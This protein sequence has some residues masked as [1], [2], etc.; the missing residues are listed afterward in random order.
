MRTTSNTY[1]FNFEDCP[2][3]TEGEPCEGDTCDHCDNQLKNFNVEF[4]GVTNVPGCE[5]DN[6]VA[7]FWNSTSFLIT[8]CCFCECGNTQ[9]I[10]D[11]DDN[12]TMGH[13]QIA[14]EATQL[15]VVVDEEGTEGDYTDCPCDDSTIT[16]RE[17]GL[18]APYDCENRTPTFV[19]QVVNGMGTN[20]RSDW[21]GA[22]CT[23]TA[24]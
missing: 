24:A 11:P 15:T 16:F 23:L 13:L 6:D 8:N 3:C 12:F 17:V 18:V 21:S 22:S 7:N 14:Y 4:S 5:C 9:Y 1:T 2:C 19:D 20:F 10:L